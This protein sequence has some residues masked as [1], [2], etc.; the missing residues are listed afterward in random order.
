MTNETENV[1]ALKRRLERAM[2]AGRM[3]SFEWDTKSDTV[4]RSENS[5][6]ILGFDPETGVCDTGENHFSHIHDSDRPGFVQ[7]VRGLTPDAPEYE[8][9]YRFVRGDGRIIWLEESG[10]AEFDENGALARVEGMASD[11]TGFV[12]KEKRERRTETGL[13]AAQTALN[14]VNA[15]GEG[16]I[17]FRL[18][19]T[20][21]TVNPAV[22]TLTALRRQDLLGR[23]LRDVLPQLLEGDDLA[24]AQRSLDDVA[25]GHTPAFD[26]VALK[27][28]SAPPVIVSPGVT[29]IRS[30]DGT[31]DCAVLTLKDVTELHQA[32]ELLNQIF[33][34]TH[35]QIVYLDTSFDF[36]RVNRAYAEA[37]GHEPGFFPGKNH[38]DLFPHPENETIFRS[39]RDTGE[40]FTVSE[41]AFEFPDHPERGVTYWDWSLRPIRNEKGIMQGLLF[42]LL[43]ATDR[44]RARRKQTESDQKYRD[45]VENANSIILRITPDHRILF[46]NEYAQSFFGY[47][48][49]ELLGRSVIGTIVPSVDSEGRDLRKMTK[50]ITANP[51]LHGTNEN[52]NTCKDGRRVWIRWANRALRDE[53]GVVREILCVGTDMTEKRRLTK[54]ADLYRERLQRLADRL[55][56][57]EEQE[58]RRVADHIHDTVVQMLSLSNIRLGGVMAALEKAGMSDQRERVKGVRQLLDEGTRECRGLMEELVPSLLYEVGLHAALSDFARKQAKTVG[59]SIRVEGDDGSKPLDDAL[60]GL[61]FQCAREL[62]MNAEKYAGPCV[63]RVSFSCADGHV[64]LRVQDNGRGFDPVEMNGGEAHDHAEGGF[65]LFNIRERLEG[66]GGRLDIDSTPDKGTIATVRVP[67]ETEK[68]DGKNTIGL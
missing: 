36:V 11:A 23:N 55:T 20:I 29:W 27:R 13:A 57:T 24:M 61:L 41:M 3:F 47:S 7:L 14:I 19:G 30:S 21:T 12:E 65:G 16:V 4:W 5:V 26:H 62:I 33:D 59:T 22:E 39:V 67:L 42:C 63:I 31:I 50:D 1:H 64:Q 8:T 68:T 51:E 28:E 52:E 53:H 35:M 34:N 43:D 6:A 58:R 38:F 46:F 54:E 40:P 18:N 45:L 25:H 10:R 17:L 66:L 49:E 37:C 15:M 32:G 48:A 44:V 56:A 60:R 9:T 2:A